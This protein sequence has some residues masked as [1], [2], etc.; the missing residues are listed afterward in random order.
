MIAITQLFKDILEE[1]LAQRPFRQQKLLTMTNY[2]YIELSRCSLPV[3]AVEHQHVHYLAKV[4]ELEGLVDLHYKT[5]KSP[6]DYAALMSMTEKHLNRI[7]KTTLN[8][9]TGQLITDRIVLEAR[10]LLV[11]TQLPVSRVAEDLGYL[12][13]SYFS[14]LFKKQSGE[15][16]LAFLAKYRR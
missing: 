15:T 6:R 16:P 7:C 9:T 3:Q 12:D 11:Q 13:H 5:L 1:Q 14:R 10:R 8:K 4:R 2:V